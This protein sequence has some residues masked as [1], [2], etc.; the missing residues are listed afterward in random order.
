M[1]EVAKVRH[2]FWGLRCTHDKKY[3]FVIDV[4][5][6]HSVPPSLHVQPI[7][8]TIL[9]HSWDMSQNTTRHCQKN[10]IYS[11]NLQYQVSCR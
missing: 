1:N 7:Y 6:N 5:L 9:V 10:E 8:N 11:I 3:M 2:L 4:V